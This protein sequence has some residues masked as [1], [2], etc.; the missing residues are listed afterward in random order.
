MDT[1]D[2][3]EAAFGDVGVGGSLTVHL[4]SQGV[5]TQRGLGR[6]QELEAS[7]QTPRWG[8]QGPFVR[9]VRLRLALEERGKPGREAGVFL[10]GFE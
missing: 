5:E 6:V 10:S 9:R 4:A 3:E 2:Q 8:S 7:G 1:E